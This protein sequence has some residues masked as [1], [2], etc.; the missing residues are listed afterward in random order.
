MWLKNRRTERSSPKTHQRAVQY[1]LSLPLH[2]YISDYS[3]LLTSRQFFGIVLFAKIQQN[4]E[5]RKTHKSTK[6]RIAAALTA[7]I[8]TATLAAPTIAMETQAI[9]GKQL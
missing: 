2:F 7:T 6:K 5:W 8:L 4:T 1:A 9:S 3:F